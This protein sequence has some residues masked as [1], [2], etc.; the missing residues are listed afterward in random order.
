M[1]SITKNMMLAALFAALTAIFSQ[2]VIPLPFTPIPINLATAA[3][4]L[5]GALL[6]SFWG[7]VS[8]VVFILL[9]VLG[10]PVFAKF[11]SG[12]GTLVGPTGGYILG[13]V[14]AAALIGVLLKENCSSVWKNAGAMTAGLLVCYILGTSWF[15]IFTQRGLW[16]SLTACVFPFLLGDGIK[17]ALCAFLARRLAP[18]R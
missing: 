2:L 8:Q 17:I 6:G 3:V 5:A 7:S 1:K 12:I 4:F 10:L 13:Y 18:Y 15:M 11:S 14:A 9:G 16:A